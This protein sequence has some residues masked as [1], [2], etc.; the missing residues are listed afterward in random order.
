AGRL[1]Q[2][3]VALVFGNDI[4]PHALRIIASPQDR[5]ESIVIADE[6]ES[7]DRGVDALTHEPLSR[8]SA[9]AAHPFALLNARAFCLIA[10]FSRYTTPSGDELSL[11]S[12]TKARPIS[13]C[14]IVPNR[15]GIRRPSQAA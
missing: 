11:N 13:S 5:R 12:A 14:S 7:A 4:Q 3:R 2:N 6:H 15:P 1:D 8:A 9:S 10:P